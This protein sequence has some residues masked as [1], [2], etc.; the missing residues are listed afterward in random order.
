[1][2]TTKLRPWD[3]AQQLK[4]E[5]DMTLYLEACFKEGD[6]A[7]IARALGIIAKAKGMIQ[8]ARDTGL[9]LDSLYTALSGEGDSEF[10][11]VMKVITTLGFRLRVESIV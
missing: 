8:L 2:G 4:T 7:L 6:A 1:M 3:S 11:T 10:A 5:E 9:S